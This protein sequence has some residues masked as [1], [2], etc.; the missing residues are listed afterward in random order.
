MVNRR[1]KPTQV[2]SLIRKLA[3]EQQLNIEELPGRG[4]GS[5]RI[6]ALTDSSGSEV[7]RFGITGHARDVSWAVLTAIEDGLEHLFGEKWMEKRR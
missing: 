1:M 5:H 2:M 3:R 4:K 6:Y 7:A